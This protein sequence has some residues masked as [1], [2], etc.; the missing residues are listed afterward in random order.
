MVGWIYL[1][2][3]EYW[4]TE[5]LGSSI[6]TNCKTCKKSQCPHPYLRIQMSPMSNIDVP[7]MTAIVNTIPI[8]IPLGRFDIIST[9]SSNVSI[10][11]RCFSNCMYS[12]VITIDKMN[13]FFKYYH[14]NFVIK[15]ML[16]ECLY[17]IFMPLKA[18]LLFTGC[19]AQ[20]WKF[21]YFPFCDMYISVTIVL[22]DTWVG[23]LLIIE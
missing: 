11:E 22:Y 5:C 20:L 3:T 7:M 10:P 15:D 16:S 9:T 8:A 12:D 17:A 13:F 18:P 21:S 4:L 2:T 6:L 23:I 14:R 1:S 19:S